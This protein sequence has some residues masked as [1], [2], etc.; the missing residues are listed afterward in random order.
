M[1]AAR[2]MMQSKPKAEESF[3]GE[4]KLILSNARR[5]MHLIPGT[6][7]LAL[8]AAALLMALVSAC[9]TAFP[10]TIGLLVDEVKTE[11]EQRLPSESIGHTA[12]LFL[13]A[14]AGIFLMR[15]ALQVVRRY[16][17]ENACTRIE[18]AMTVQA[19][20]H[21]LKADLTAL[22]QEKIGVVHGRLTRSVVGFVRFIRLAF[23]DFF[24]PLLTGLFALAVALSKQPLLGIVMAGLIPASLYLTLRQLN[25]QKGIRLALIRSREEMD[26][27][28]IEQLGAVDYVRAAN[29]HEQEVSRIADAAERRRDMENRHH[30]QMSLFGCAK[31]L[32]EGL[33]HILLLAMAVYLAINGSASYGDVLVY[34]LLFNNVLAPLNEVHRVLDEGHECSLMS[35]DLFQMIEEPADPSFYPHTNQ[36]PQPVPGHP[37]LVMEDVVV[38]NGC[39]RILEGIST[40]IHHGETVGLAGP[41]GGGKTTWLRVLLRLTHPTSGRVLIGG[42]PVDMVSRDAIGRLFGYVGQA[43]FVFAGTIEE[44]IR[45]GNPE[46]TAE[47]L[48]EAAC[49]AYIH[50]E[51]M[52]FQGGYQ[53]YVKERGLNLSAGQRQRLALARVFLKNPPI[54]VLD[55][56]TSALD[57][58]SE[59]RIQSAINAARQERTVILV[60]HRLSTLLNADRIYVF[61]AGQVA[62]AGT[63]LELYQRGGA[64]TELVNCAGAGA[65][66]PTLA[67]R[68]KRPIEFPNPGL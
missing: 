61:Q 17:V 54:L 33:F 1:V 34:S 37:V 9:N 48:Q 67:C 6:Y 32:N 15:E 66:T 30:L 42:V 53:A 31:A 64:F 40:V 25:S 59:H 13:G 28:V 60:A 10:L 35:A 46:A 58:I 18:K 43:P 16:L 24:P 19:F 22:T 49:R 29:T 23:L 68:P 36:E 38:Q 44:N 7:Q 4:A 20:S 41:S 5:A 62:E 39:K 65:A 14:L 57:T 52:Q 26:G 56:G 2:L 3:L 63:Y 55:E 27:T 50:D 51:I 21:L 8:G 12:G 11:A 47:A 45:Y